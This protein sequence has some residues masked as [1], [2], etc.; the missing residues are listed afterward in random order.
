MPSK[1]VVLIT[2]AN[3]GIGYEAAKA[4]LQSKK[5]YHVL[6]GARSREKGEAATDQLQ[7]EIFVSPSSIEFVQVD[8]LSNESI[9][10]A[11]QTVEAKYGVLDVL[12]NNAGVALDFV[13]QNG[14]DD[15]ELR[16]VRD[17]FDNSYRTNATG[18]HVMTHAFAPLLVKSTDPRLLFVTSGLATLAS[19]RENGLQPHMKTPNV[20][21]GWPKPSLAKAQGAYRSS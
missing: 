16:V 17:A 8:I 4:L 3:S 2:G 6:L 5:S 14:D 12:I 11:F 9:R 13:S 7:K 20:P 1:T 15:D 21:A 18:S 10:E 19:T